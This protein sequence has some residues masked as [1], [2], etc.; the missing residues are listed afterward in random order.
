MIRQGT[1]QYKEILSLYE[2]CKKMG[3]TVSLGDA[4]DGYM[5]VFAEGSYFTQHSGSK[6][7]EEGLI[8]P[9]IGGGYDG[10]GVPLIKAKLLVRIHS[11]R[12]KGG[13]KDD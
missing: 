5:V 10:E 7:S 8:E 2:Y 12:L 11:D 3:L 6:G 1:L 9:H 4:N 13:G